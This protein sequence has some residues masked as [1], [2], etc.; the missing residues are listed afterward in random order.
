MA[1]VSAT[2]KLP[3]KV[4]NVALALFWLDGMKQHRGV[5]M[6]RQ[7]LQLFNVSDDAYRDALVRLEEAGLI[8]VTRAAGQRAQ[9]EIVRYADPV[10][11]PILEVLGQ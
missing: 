4:I 10:D 11:L 3:E 9:V 5:R 7:A 6:T 1:W 8:S 2:A